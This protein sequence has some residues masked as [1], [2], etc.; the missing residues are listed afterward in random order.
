MPRRTTK[1]QK[2]PR[3]PAPKD[4]FLRELR[5]VFA[6]LDNRHQR[7]FLA[8]FARGRGVCEAERL[9][10]VTRVSHNKW[11]R[12]APRYRE[13]FALVRLMLADD[14]E[15]EAYRRAFKGV[16]TPI[17]YRGKI[18]GWTRSY[19]DALAMFMLKGMKPEVYGRQAVGNL[20]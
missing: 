4:E 8:G 3:P 13:C 6:G 5:E 14:A 10:G 16:E 9:S 17:V 12:E 19:S 15:E 7:A 1:A 11:L 2:P 18:R 20:P